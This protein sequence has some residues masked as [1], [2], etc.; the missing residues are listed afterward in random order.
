M[1]TPETKMTPTDTG[2]GPPNDTKDRNELQAMSKD[3]LIGLYL[4]TIQMRDEY[5]LVLLSLI[6]LTKNYNDGTAETRG[7]EG[8]M[9]YVDHPELSDDGTTGP[10]F[11]FAR[12]RFEQIAQQ[13]RA[14]SNNVT[15]ST[16]MHETLDQESVT[17]TQEQAV[18]FKA[19]EAAKRHFENIGRSETFLLTEAYINDAYPNM[20]RQHRYVIYRNLAR[21]LHI[22]DTEWR[23][24]VN[25]YDL[26]GSI[27][28]SVWAWWLSDKSS[29][30]SARLGDKLVSV[31]MTVSW[32]LNTNAFAPAA[33]E[34]DLGKYDIDGMPDEPR[35]NV[36]DYPK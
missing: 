11:K 9:H 15:S 14:R 26:N 22:F 21:A 18:L 3:Q 33:T 25:H 16:P 6:E 23:A 20:P 8:I 13:P 28:V 29:R 17:D 5:T 32:E 24:C 2:T 30:V 19:R 10:W 27:P 31:P 36:T 7:T 35:W 34:N 4:R 12:E 1:D